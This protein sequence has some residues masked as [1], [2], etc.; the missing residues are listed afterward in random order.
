MYNS[1]SCST[2][3]DFDSLIKVLILL[4]DGNQTGAD[5]IGHEVSLSKSIAP[6]KALNTKVIAIAIGSVDKKQLLEMVEQEE[7]ILSP[8]NFNELKNYVK[9]TISYS[10]RGEWFTL[11]C[12]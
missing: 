3:T 6:L 9:Q 8:K 12:V 2:L 10:C 4:T 7:D 1:L 5:K 11:S